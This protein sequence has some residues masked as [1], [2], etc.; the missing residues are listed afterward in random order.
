MPK[1]FAKQPPLQRRNKM[2]VTYKIDNNFLTNPPSYYPRVSP[3]ETLDIEDLARQIN[4]HNPNMPYNSI[5]ATLNLFVEEVLFQL[6]EGNWVKIEN[7]CSFSTSII[8]AVMENSSDP[9]PGTAKIDIKAKPAAPFKELVRE[10]ASISRDGI[11]AKAPQ[12]GSAA[13]AMYGENY[14]AEP[15]YGLIIGGSD[16]AFDPTDTTQGV[17]IKPDGGSQTRETNI[18]NNKPK[19]VTV[20]PSVTP[21]SA[22]DTAAILTVKARYTANGQL[23]SGTSQKPIRLPNELVTQVANP[24]FKTYGVTEA[25][26]VET[27]VTSGTHMLRARISNLNELYF[28]GKQHDGTSWGDWGTEVLAD[29]DD[30]YTVSAG[31][32]DFDIEVTDYE[33]LFEQ[34][35]ALGRYQVELVLVSAA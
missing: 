15:G 24:I 9:L 13:H 22:G 26:T 6:K 10:Q 12:I 31:V 27:S 35:N 30:T 28:A 17:F 5:L 14:I 21:A 29:G 25:A 2:P 33:E 16:L 4:L 7:F 3:V 11:I 20:I 34:L 23:K 19:N 1:R 18:T 8:D 32:T